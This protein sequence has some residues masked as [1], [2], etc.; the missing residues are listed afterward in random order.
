M[1]YGRFSLACLVCCKTGEERKKL[2]KELL[3]KGG[4]A[5]QKETSLENAQPIHRVYSGDW[6]NGL[7]G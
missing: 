1:K 2:R 4:T 5:K 3:S 6:A 7:A